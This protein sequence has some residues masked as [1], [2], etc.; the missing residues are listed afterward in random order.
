MKASVYCGFCLYVAMK[1]YFVNLCA[2]D[3]GTTIRVHLVEKWAE[4]RLT[5]TTLWVLVVDII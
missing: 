3:E 5:I 4:R 1:A 2:A